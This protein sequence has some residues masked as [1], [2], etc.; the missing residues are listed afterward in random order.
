[1]EEAIEDLKSANEDHQCCISKLRTMGLEIRGQIPCIHLNPAHLA[2]PRQIYYM[3]FSREEW[4]D[5]RYQTSDTIAHPTGAS[6]SCIGEEDIRGLIHDALRYCRS[7]KTF[8]SRKSLDK[9]VLQ[10]PCDQNANLIQSHSQQHCLPIDD[11]VD[12]YESKLLTE[13]EIT[14]GQGKVLRMQKM[15]IKD[16][17]RLL[18]DGERILVHVDDL[19]QPIKATGGLCT[20]FMTS[21]IGMPYTSKIDKVILDKFGSKYQ[22]IKY[23]YKNK[24]LKKAKIKLKI[25][26]EENGVYI[27]DEEKNYSQ[28]QLFEALDLANGFILCMVYVEHMLQEKARDLVAKKTMELGISGPIDTTAEY[29]IHNAI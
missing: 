26:R 23:R 4:V 25:A 22:S 16:V 8:R 19:F 10:Q 9:H 21:L 12:E 24:L 7:A 27:K 11:E 18:G 17:Y 14:D 29:E 20:R 2:H 13:V 28:E 3:D 5:S 1:M 6:G 15:S